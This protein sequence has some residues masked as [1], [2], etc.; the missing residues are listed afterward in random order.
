M[1]RLRNVPETF[2]VIGHARFEADAGD[3]SRQILPCLIQ[4]GL[5]D[6]NRV[7]GDGL[8]TAHC[9]RKKEPGFGSCAR[10]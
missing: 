7:I 5:R 1:C 3:R 4:R 9:C 10:A 8:L 6:V 2:G